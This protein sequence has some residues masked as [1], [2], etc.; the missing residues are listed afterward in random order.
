MQAIDAENRIKLLRGGRPSATPF[1]T[2][3]FSDAASTLLD[4]KPTEEGGR[5]RKRRRLP[6]EDDTER[7]IR[8]ARE[9]A[10]RA[11]SKRQE[12]LLT[13][14]QDD[15]NAFTLLDS[16]G[17]INLFPEDSSSKKAEKNREAEAEAQEKRQRHDDQY[18]MRFSNAAGFKEQVNRQPWYSSTNRTVSAPDAVADKDVWGNEDT[19]RKEREKARM[20]ANDPLAVMKRGVRQLKAT[21]RERKRWNEEKQKELEALK[22]EER[23][24]SKRSPSIDSFDSFKLDQLAHKDHGEK[25]HRSSRRHHRDS[26]HRST[27]SRDTLPRRKHHISA[28]SSHHHHNETHDGSTRV[29]K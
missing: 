3:S 5:Y 25:H 18:T 21:E 16:A 7:D 22:T 19:M 14:R 26:H 28:D 11:D 9:D 4:K 17:H 27:R 23:R 24:R 10:I 2:A 13:S 15:K 29:Q 8:L 6:G 1:S 12:L 20:N